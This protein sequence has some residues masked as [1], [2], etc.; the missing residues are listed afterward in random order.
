MGEMVKSYANTSP[1]KDGVLMIDTKTLPSG[2]YVLR[3]NAG[4]VRVTKKLVIQ[5]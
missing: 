4:D 1:T 5:K 2:V 3:M